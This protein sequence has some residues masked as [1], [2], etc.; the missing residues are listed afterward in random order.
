MTSRVCLPCREM[1]PQLKHCKKDPNNIVDLFALSGTQLKALYVTYCRG[2]HRSED[3]YQDHIEY[4]QVR[5]SNHILLNSFVPNRSWEISSKID[6]VY[7]TTLFCQ[8]RGSL[9]TIFYSKTTWSIP[10]RQV[11]L[12]HTLNLLLQ[13]L[14]T[15]QDELTMLCI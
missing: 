9:N 11:L 14:M 8:Y 7:V 15:F 10:S 6:L 4:L 3:I 5:C 13:S 12:F 2:K 1:L